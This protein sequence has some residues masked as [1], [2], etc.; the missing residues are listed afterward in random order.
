MPY[1]RGKLKGEL[2]SAE[3][4]K[5]VRLHNEMSKIKIPPRLDRDGLI[6]FIE[7]KGFKIDHANKK[8]VN[9]NEVKKDLTLKEAQEKFPTKPRKK[10]ETK[11]EEKKE[12]LKLDDK[13][14]PKQDDAPKFAV[15]KALRKRQNKEIKEKF[16]MG[17]MD[18]ILELPDLFSSTPAEIKKACRKLQ[19]K[20]HPD[21]TG[22]DDERFKAVR[23]S[24][25]FMV[26]SFKELKAGEKPV[27]EDKIS[28]DLIVKIKKFMSD[29][30]ASNIK[31]QTSIDDLQ[32]LSD[33][34]VD[35]YNDIQKTFIDKLGF[36]KK[37]E[38]NEWFNEAGINMTDYEKTEKLSLR[39]IRA[40]VKVLKKK[41]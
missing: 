2:K 11:K 38:M 13:P 28:K 1:L 19:L 24:C 41:K 35:M 23:E 37:F 8:I 15:N 21:K 9:K 34:G 33:D 27:N 20:Y 4:R 29:L 22:G 36:K 6:K 18:K 12:V 32:K 10:K 16:K 17:G 7:S 26:A 39:R 25:D 14:A 3:I 40:R 31:K 30:S 5:I